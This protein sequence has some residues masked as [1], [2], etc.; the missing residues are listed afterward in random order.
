MLFFEVNEFVGFANDGPERGG[1]LQ[2]YEN[3]NQDPKCEV[4]STTSAHTP[5]CTVNDSEAKNETN[6][7]DSDG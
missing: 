1:H 2:G 6:N 5:R 3:K 7:P 4:S